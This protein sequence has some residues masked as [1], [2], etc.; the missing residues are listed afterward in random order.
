MNSGGADWA[1]PALIQ[2]LQ[3]DISHLREMMD[4]ARRETAA[5]RE[6][7]RKELDGL[8]E[9]LR[10]VRSQLGPIVNERQQTQK[11]RRAVLWDW[12]GKGGWVLIA[13]AA[14][15]IW[16]YLAKHLGEGR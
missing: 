1:W 13:G 12:I 10:E 16:H 8:I 15:A 7:H 5:S 14:M 3:H 4:D 9:Q 2:S 11:A 6:L